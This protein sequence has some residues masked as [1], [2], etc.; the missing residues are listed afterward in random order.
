M[1]VMKMAGKNDIKTDEIQNLYT[2]HEELSEA[3]IL[4]DDSLSDD[5]TLEPYENEES[6]VDS[7]VDSVFDSGMASNEEYY[8]QKNSTEI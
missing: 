4:L 3:D 2:D 7:V 5:N 1:S 6:I 8:E